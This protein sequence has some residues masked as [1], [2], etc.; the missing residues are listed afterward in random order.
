MKRM[1]TKMM[2]TRTTRRSES[3][4]TSLR[5]SLRISPLLL[6]D[7]SLKKLLVVLSQRLFKSS[8]NIRKEVTAERREQM[9]ERA[10]GSSNQAALDKVNQILHRMEDPTKRG[11]KAIDSISKDQ[12]GALR[13]A[14]PFTRRRISINLGRSVLLL[15]PIPISDCTMKRI[16][17][18]ISIS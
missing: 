6:I 16:P 10:P 11:G 4:T 9:M 12:E 2:T 13:K 17:N 3:T 8:I 15:I 1:K 7:R 5:D 14:A 18:S